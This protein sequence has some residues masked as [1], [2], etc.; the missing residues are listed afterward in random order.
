MQKF[1]TLIEECSVVLV[2]FQNEMFSLTQMKTGAKV[3]RDAA[4][5]KR[6]LHSCGMK[7]PRHH[8]GR[9]GL[10]MRSPHHHHFLPPHEF[11]MQQLRQR[12]ERNALV[13]H[14]LEFGV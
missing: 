2:A 9:R 5:Q 3:F 1:R 11:L 8:R 4:D 14:L 7:N 12:A 6:W 13:E 10:A